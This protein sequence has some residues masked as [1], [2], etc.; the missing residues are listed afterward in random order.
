MKRY[1]IEGI[2]TGILMLAI[3]CTVNSDIHVDLQPLVI[4]MLLTIAIY[5]GAHISDAH[6]NPVV[7]LGFWMRGRLTLSELLGYVIGQSVGILLAVGVGVCVLGKI[8]EAP[9]Q[10]MPLFQG[11]V[12]EAIG[13]YVLV[14]VILTVATIPKHR[15]NPLNGLII[16]M[17]VVGLI[18]IF[19]SV[20]SGACFNPAVAL[21]TLASGLNT[22]AN[23]FPIILSNIV[24]A[25]LAAVTLNLTNP[26]DD[27]P[28]R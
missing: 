9:P 3:I 5:G 27:T 16:G 21:G 1:C 13:A 24:G 11:S 12:V 7:S 4:G 15:S 6:Y 19:R 10:P 28:N 20:G 26:V 22:T 25:V 18:Y 8:P 14:W 17:T 2:G 23:M